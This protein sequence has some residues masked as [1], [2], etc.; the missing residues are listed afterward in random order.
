VVEHRT[1]TLEPMSRQD[2]E[3]ATRAQGGRATG[4]VSKSTDFLVAGASP[5]ASKIK[6]AEKHGTQVIDERELL[7]LL[8]RTS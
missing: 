7:E 3:E 2:A 8:G 4:S 1:G 5:G 6:G